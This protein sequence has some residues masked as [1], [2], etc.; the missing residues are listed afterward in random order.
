MESWSDLLLAVLF[1]RLVALSDLL[2]PLIEYTLVTLFGL[3]ACRA[4]AVRGSVGARRV[5]ARPCDAVA[6]GRKKRTGPRE[7]TST[8]EASI[9]AEMEVS[10]R[11]ELITRRS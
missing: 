1:Y 5:G 2:W 8:D 4:H 11:E 7:R 3:L 10:G 6:Q 9:R